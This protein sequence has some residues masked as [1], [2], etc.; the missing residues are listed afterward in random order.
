MSGYLKDHVLT[1][2]QKFDKEY[3]ILNLK[4]QKEYWVHGIGNLK[5]DANG[6]LLEMFGTIQDITERKELIGELQAA[7]ENVKVLSGLVP[8][9][10]SCKNIRDDKGYWNQID[11][12]IEE[13]SDASFSHGICPKCSDE[14]Y[15]DQKW[16]KKMKKEKKNASST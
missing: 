6:K 2:H 12:Y 13:H 3:K 16:Y 7:L 15:G 5:F 1:S 9:C 4:D 11:S 8:I 10:S 14:L